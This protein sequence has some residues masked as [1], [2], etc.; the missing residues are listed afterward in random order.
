MF[1]FI[2]TIPDV[3]ERLINRIESP[4]IQ[5]LFVRLI[6]AEHNGLPGVTEWLAEQGLI[7]R[8][9]EFL[10]PQYPPTLHVIAADLLKGIVGVCAPSPSFD[11]SAVAEENAGPGGPG[12]KNNRLIREMV[13]EESID[14]MTG[15]MLD[16]IELSDRDWKGLNGEG[17]ESSPADP[18]VVH[19]LPSIA[20]ASS[21]LSQI[22]M[23]LVELIRRNNSDY[24]EPHLFHSLRTRL[25]SLRNQQLQSHSENGRTTAVDAADREAMEIAMLEISPKMGIVHL[26]GLLRKII[27]RFGELHRFLLEPRS[28]VSLNSAGPAPIQEGVGNTTDMSD[29]DPSILIFGFETTHDGTIPDY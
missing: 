3:V 11:P 2:R 9:I 23:V 16:D 29:L 1:W 25:M 19:P 17:R 26:G 10:S 28:Q 27:D 18:F 24:S 8:L 13:S 4:A 6:T 20:S 7:S 14:K 21:S 15:F 12:S 22:C 5:D